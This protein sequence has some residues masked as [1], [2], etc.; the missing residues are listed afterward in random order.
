MRATESHV[1]TTARMPWTATNTPSVT[2]WLATVNRAEGLR[3]WYVIVNG[4]A[5]PRPGTH[6]QHV[7]SRATNPTAVYAQTNTSRNPRPRTP[8]GDRVNG[9]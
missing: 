3:R 9:R 1:N 2:S 6:A 4:D 7:P 8:Q 5:V